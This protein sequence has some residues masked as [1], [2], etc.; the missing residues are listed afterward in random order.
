[1]MNMRSSSRTSMKT[2]MMWEIREESL[3]LDTLVSNRTRKNRTR[4]IFGV[5]LVR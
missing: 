3:I 1:M 2:I 4:E 5:L